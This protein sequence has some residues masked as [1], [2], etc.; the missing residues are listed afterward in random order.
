VS[1]ERTPDELGI[2][3]VPEAIVECPSGA[4]RPGAGV[5]DAVA[6]GTGQSA[7]A[8]C[9]KADWLAPTAELPAAGPAAPGTA[10]PAPGAVA[11]TEPTRERVRRWGREYGG[12]VAAGV[13]ATVVLICALTGVPGIDMTW[14]NPVAAD[15]PSAAAQSPSAVVNSS[16]A[17]PPSQTPT[18]KPTKRPAAAPKPRAAA[19]SP[20]PTPGATMLGPADGWALSGLVDKYC[21]RRFDRSA[22]LLRPWQGSGA[23]DN[24]A[25]QRRRRSDVIIA[26]MTDACV[27]RYGHGAVASYRDARDPFSWRCYRN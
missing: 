10:A 23:Q 25:C 5:P 17:G 13:V 16:P 22:T 1:D 15:S 9:Q 26:D 12:Y 20:S 19:R 21:D 2:G 4:D 3:P 11:A 6:A 14:H 18:R 27:V 24:W 7:G 8:G